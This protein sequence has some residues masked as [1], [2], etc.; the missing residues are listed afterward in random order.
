MKGTF[1]LRILEI[2]GEAATSSADLVSAFLSAGYGAS[3]G[4]LSR[5]LRKAESEREARAHK[6]RA[7]A[8]LRRRYHNIV[9]WLQRENLIVKNAGAFRI[10]SRGR[11]KLQLLRE[12]KGREL[13]ETAYPREKASRV[14]I[15]AFDVPEKYRRKRSWLRTA[16]KEL[17]LRMVQKSLWIGKTKIPTQFLDDLRELKLVEYIEIFEV[18]KAG[19]LEHVV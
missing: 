4:K 5:E 16:L 7:E 3:Y 1:A 10:T 6:R 11:R 12:R 14:I 17:G 13:P 9:S 2:V 8:L 18:D 19:T 15:V